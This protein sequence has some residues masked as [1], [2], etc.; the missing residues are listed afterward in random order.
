MAL[1]VYG[2]SFTLLKT[3]STSP[4][5]TAGYAIWFRFI[6][7]IFGNHNGSSLTIHTPFCEVYDFFNY[8]SS[9]FLK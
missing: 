3:N 2:K 5:A 7:T 6:A 4:I 1:K 8:T 9:R